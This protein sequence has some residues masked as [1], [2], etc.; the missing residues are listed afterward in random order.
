MQ[1]ITFG[2]RIDPSVATA[3]MRRFT[4][5][6]QNS[7]QTHTRSVRQQGA[8]VVAVHRQT[9]A[10]K[11]RA[12]QQ[13]INQI[14]RE[15]QKR[16]A[17]SIKV[18]N[19]RLREEQRAAREIARITAETARQAIAQERIRERAAKQLADVQ[20]REA[21][22][23]AR[24]LENSL[25]QS[26]GGGG[27][28]FNLGALTDITGQVPALGG[29]TSQLHALTSATTG[30]G[31]ATAGLAGPIGIAIGLFL[32][33]AAAVAA[34][35]HGLFDLAKRT[36]DFQGKLFDMSQQV[37]V[38]VE[39]LS[40]LEIL[41]T[42]TGGNIETVA[43]S[44]AIFQKNLEAAHDPTSKEAKLLKDLGVTATDTEEALD[45]ALR[46]L[47]EMGEGSAQT[48]A[49]LELFG[50]SGRFVNA[51]LKE[52]N[53]D[54][55]EAKKRFRELGIEISTASA[56]ASDDFNDSMATVNFQLRALTA[57]VGNATIPT[58]TKGF[59]E[60]QKI[61]KDNKDGFDALGHAARGVAVLIGG[62]LLGAVQLAGVA[63]KTHNFLVRQVAE[64]YESAAAAAQLFSGN[65]PTVD[66]NAIPAQPTTPGVIDGV[67]LLQELQK[68]FLA[69]QAQE[70][71]LLKPFDQGL[72]D[73]F[74]EKKEKKDNTD[75]AATAK[76]IAELT[77]S[78]TVAGLN[79]EEAAIRRSLARR[80]VNFEEYVHQI[81]VLEAARHLRV[82]AGLT[83]EAAAAEKLRDSDQRRIALKEIENRLEQENNRHK[84]VGNRLDDERF[85]I[86]QQI[87]DFTE[88]QNREVA[89][90]IA[91]NSRWLESVDNL[92][93]SLARQGAALTKT[94]E[95]WLRFNAVIGDSIERMKRL[96]DLM[97]ESVNLV[98]PPGIVPVITP[99]QDAA[100][101][102][103]IADRAAG[104][105]PPA[106][107]PTLDEMVA[108]AVQAQGAFA[109]LG[110]AMSDVFG[111]GATGAVAFGESMAA[112][113]GA[114]AQAAGEAVRAFVLFGTAQGGF[115]KFA[116][117]VIASIAQ[118][119]VVQA[120]WEGAQ[121]LAMLALTWFTGNPKY[122]A[123]AG[124]HFAAA[125][126]YGIVA[127]VAVP[128]GRAVAGNTF[129]QD[130][131]GGAGSGSDSGQPN[132]L[133]PL[134]LERN[135]GE[136]RHVIEI[137]FRPED[138]HIVQT[139][140]RD[141]QSGGNTREVINS[142]GVRV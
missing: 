106:V 35:A 11:L 134:A 48:A 84:E 7:L 108:A 109:G 135:M 88:Q 76:R 24:E 116:A 77:L 130:G 62:P 122:A 59:R 104:P 58:I 141:Y 118:M 56:K 43:A 21:K 115:R 111:L 8:A 75:P 72:K 51:I 91:V 64:A 81:T 96:I 105:P 124:A 113:F 127:G 1:E 16:V 55:G 137:R 70:K 49:V 57:Q 73:L 126:A 3:E 23:A 138:A 17:E 53:G 142:D 125:A 128:L 69:R 66:P 86:Q 6:T 129:Q 32:A 78:N 15:E 110:V 14:A 80:E 60:T 36:A 52:S 18:A 46:A 67:K 31:A 107:P 131:G 42:T 114:V 85:N 13:S 4:A 87:I 26:R 33:E 65:I 12:F 98:P 45:Q 99:E 121:G 112:A 28:G 136:R 40:A 27:G 68:A 37:G 95:H 38:S 140:V 41:A 30:A 44:L 97:R 74:G 102:G 79:A 50:R 34:V 61:I 39:T 20:I 92:I 82:I 29:L 83:G 89:N 119:A 139:F 25:K 9:E 132:Q 63:L 103:A 54:L 2:L 117:E 71:A 22:R 5:V 47:F 90:A 10:Q 93:R 100:T 101:A 133:N 123:S 120:I 19:Q 94:Q